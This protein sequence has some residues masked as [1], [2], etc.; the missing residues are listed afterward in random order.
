M[1]V[2]SGFTN[3]EMEKEKKKRR[4]VNSNFELMKMSEQQQQVANSLIFSGSKTL[5]WC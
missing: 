4:N 1:A 5:G 3:Q 2:K